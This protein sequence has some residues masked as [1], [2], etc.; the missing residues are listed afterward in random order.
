MQYNF[1]LVLLGHLLLA[2]SPHAVRKPSSQKERPLVGLSAIV[3]AEAP[4]DRQT[5]TTR[6]I[7]ELLDDSSPQHLGNPNKA[8]TSSPT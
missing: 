6:H 5:S 8:K 7:R 4:I 3:P 2:S 1:H